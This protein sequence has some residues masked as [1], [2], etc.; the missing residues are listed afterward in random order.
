VREALRQVSREDTWRWIR[1]DHLDREGVQRALV[2]LVQ[3]LLQA[4][5]RA[6]R[7]A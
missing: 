5:G 7:T 4:R 1:A 3:E 6:A 2:R